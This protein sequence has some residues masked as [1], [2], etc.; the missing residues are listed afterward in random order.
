MRLVVA[1]GVVAGHFPQAKLEAYGVAENG[2]CFSKGQ[3]VPNEKKSQLPGIS[4]FFFLIYAT[5]SYLTVS[6]LQNLFIFFDLP[7]LPLILAAVFCI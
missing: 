4:E 6:G 7:F 5:Y 3:A 1:C 2:F